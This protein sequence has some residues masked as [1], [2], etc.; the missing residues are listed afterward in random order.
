MASKRRFCPNCGSTH[1]EPDTSNGAEVA[2]S[3]G[4][5]NRWQCRDCGYT[6]LMPEGNPN[7]D[8][9]GDG[10]QDIEFEPKENYSRT[11]TGFGRGYLKYWIYIG[12]PAL[13]LYAIAEILL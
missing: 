1:V 11:Y 8:Q 7:A 13:I 3:G 6:G 5:L 4:N 9:D 10:K 12:I 2:V